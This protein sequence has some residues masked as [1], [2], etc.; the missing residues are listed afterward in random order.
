MK[1]KITT[2]AL[3]MALLLAGSAT[4]QVKTGSFKKNHQK[5]QISATDRIHGPKRLQAPPLMNNNK[6]IETTLAEVFPEAAEV[7]VE[8]PW[9]Q[10]LDK[11]GKTLGYAVYSTPASDSIYGYAAQTHVLIAFNKKKVITGVYLLPNL[12]SEPYVQKMRTAGF[13][14]QWNGLTVKKAK[15]KRPDA[16]SGATFTSR[17]VMRSVQAALVKIQL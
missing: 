7:K 3:A 4:A 8:G 9:N 1:G 16:V 5:E 12:E 6:G 15:A 10:V 11:D 14:D 13:F 17:G 2:L